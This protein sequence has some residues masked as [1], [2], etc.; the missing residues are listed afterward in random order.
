MKKTIQGNLKGNEIGESVKT[1][2]KRKSKATTEEKS[3][4]EI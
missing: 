1:R 3:N 4:P 2:I